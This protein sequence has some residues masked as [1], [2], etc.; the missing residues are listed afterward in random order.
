MTKWISVAESLPKAEEVVLVVVEHRTT[1]KVYQIITK[2]MYEDGTV[3]G[4]DSDYFF[5]FDIATYKQIYDVG[6]DDF[7]IPEGWWEHHSYGDTDNDGIGLIDGV[8]TH[9]MSLPA[10]P[11]VCK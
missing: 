1:N 6:R 7:K 4:N 9:W 3:W 8:V 11:K 5:E 2:A 10:L